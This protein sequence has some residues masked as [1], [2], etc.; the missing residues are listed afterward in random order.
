MKQKLL[1]SIDE[2]QNLCYMS[3]K[4]SAGDFAKENFPK[5]IE[6]FWDDNKTDEDNLEAVKNMFETNRVLNQSMG[7]PNAAQVIAA[8]QE[9][10]LNKIEV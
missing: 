9:G 1:R 10:W 3:M 6:N 2:F 7:N 8:Y 5:L 4:M